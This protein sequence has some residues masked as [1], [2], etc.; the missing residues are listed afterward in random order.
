MK[1]TSE[2]ILDLQNELR[3]VLNEQRYLHTL[4]VAYVSASLAMAHGLDHRE[5]LVA[6]LLHDCAKHYSGTELQELCKELGLTVSEHEMQLTQLLHAPYGAYLAETKYQIEKKEILLA[7]RNHTV[8]RPGMTTLEQI[9]FLA[10]Y[11]EPERKQ[12]TEPSLDE[13]RRVAFS[14][15]D[16][17]TF[18]VLKNTLK[19]L[20]STGQKMAPETME[21][22]QYYFNR[23]V[24]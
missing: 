13:I 10:D 21:T 5:A 22:Y 24:K 16:E 19:Y 9:V 1:I 15:L 14:D 18:L 17:A 3:S 8:G 2:Y 11:F 4:G 23:R 7:V 20:E 6:G 12:K